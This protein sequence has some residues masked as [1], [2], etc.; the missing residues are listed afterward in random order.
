MRQLKITKLKKVRR[1]PKDKEY[2]KVYFEA[3]EIYHSKRR[4]NYNFRHFL[5]HHS[6]ASLINLFSYARI[7]RCYKE[8]VE[9]ANAVERKMVAMQLLPPDACEKIVETGTYILEDALYSGECMDCVKLDS[10]EWCV[11]TI[12]DERK[13][14]FRELTDRTSLLRIA[15]ALAAALEE[16]VE[17]DAEAN[18][19]W[20]SQYPYP[21]YI[22][23][24]VE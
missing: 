17:R 13:I 20:F 3:K 7:N 24:S 11:R 18:E 6:S 5:R 15:D 10:G 16:L 8:L 4:E 21:E 9:I 19:Q 2:E 23:I 22:E 14:S 1:E 12:P